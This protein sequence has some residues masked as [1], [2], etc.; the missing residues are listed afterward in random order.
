MIYSDK[1]PPKET[2]CNQLLAMWIHSHRKKR[3]SPSLKI[4]L[5][6]VIFGK[7]KN[8]SIWLKTDSNRSLSTLYCLEK[9]IYPLWLNQHQN[10]F[11]LFQNVTKGK[12]SNHTSISAIRQLLLF[13]SSLWVFFFLLLV[14]LYWFTY[15][16]GLHA[17]LLLSDKFAR[18]FYYYDKFSVSIESGGNQKQQKFKNESNMPCISPSGLFIMYSNWNNSSIFKWI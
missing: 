8:E 16:A 7:S 2:N 10:Q 17:V 9:D 11:P 5:E 15:M 3:R 6:K 13:S 4:Q 14:C 18:N 12:R 1:T